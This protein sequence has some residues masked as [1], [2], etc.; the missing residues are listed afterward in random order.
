MNPTYE[1]IDLRNPGFPVHTASLART[2][3]LEHGHLRVTANHTVYSW[4]MQSVGDDDSRVAFYLERLDLSG[5]TPRLSPEV[6]VPG[7]PLGY[8]AATNRAVTAGIRSE[9]VE[10]SAQ[11]CRNHPKYAEYNWSTERCTLIDTP[12][13]LVEIEGDNASL[14][15]EQE[16]SAEAR[17][18]NVLTT[19][20]LVFAQTRE[21]REEADDEYW[22]EGWERIEVSVVTGLGG[23]DLDVASTFELDAWRLE[24]RTHEDTGR[25]LIVRGDWRSL[26][27]VDAQ[28]PSDPQVEEHPT[29][30]YCR[31][32]SV[33]ADAAYCALRQYGVHTIPLD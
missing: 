25:H 27:I 1:I 3:A 4:N 21:F 12:L 10:M 23:E 19:G 32:V 2:E 15:A 5:A 30:N 9:I 24:P 28:D 17:M 20:D 6:N 31:D 8:D 18:T 11:E 14:L 26:V 29:R 22:E 7:L 16:L 33:A 13:R